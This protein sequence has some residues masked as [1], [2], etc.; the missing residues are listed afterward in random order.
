MREK[1][2]F[3][4]YLIWFSYLIL[5][6]VLLF[7]HGFLLSRKTLNDISQCVSIEN[8][9]EKLDSAA[10]YE[11]CQNEKL[12]NIVLSSGSAI[13]C[14]P[15]RNRVVFILVDALRYDFTEFNGN[16][17]NPLYYQNRLPI[18]HET[19]TKRPNKSRVFRFMADPPTTTLQRIKALVTG[20]LPT[21]VDA[22]SNFAAM[23][24]HEDNII[25]QIY[26]NNL[27]AVLLGDDTW[28]RLLPG[29]WL[30][31]HTM[32][33]FHTWDLDTVDT[34]IDSKI[35]DELAKDDWDLLIAHYL[36]VDHA[37]HRYGPNH[38]EMARKLDE[39]NER[40]KKIIEALPTDAILYVIGD[41]GMTETGDHGGETKAERT[42]A[43]FAYY[44]GE[45]GGAGDDILVGREIQQTD[46]APTI[47]S[48]LGTSPPA[49]SLGTVLIPILP[50]MDMQHTLLHLSNNL[51][52]ITQYLV[53]YGEESQQVSLDRLAE[54]INV[55]R[56]H[57]EK[58]ATVK[59]DEQLQKYISDVRSHT[60][61]IRTVFR[62]V[63]VEFDSLAMMRSLLLLLLAIFFNWIISEGI[64]LERIPFVFS[65][66]FV[67]TGLVSV[68]ICISVCYSAFYFALLDN[69]E[70]A[71]ILSTGLISGTL[72]CALVILHWD[73]IT[74]KWYE[75][76]THFYERFARTALFA[77]AAVLV[78]NS[79][80]IEEGTVLSYLSLS[81]LGLIAWNVGTVKALGLWASCGLAL[82][83]TR[84]YRGCREEQG[85]CWTSG[86][87]G[88]TGE[89]SRGALV[90]ALG[91]VAATVS[92]ARR[93]VNWRG[94]GVVLAG[95]FTCAHFAVGWGSLGSLNRSRLLA[96]V[97]WLFIVTSFGLLL[98]K[99]RSG[100]ITPLI[101][102]SLLFYLSNCLVL[103]VSFAPTAALALLSGFLSLNVVS[104]LK[105][106]ATSKLSCSARCS[107]GLACLWSLLASYHYY[108]SGHHPTLS[109]I[110]WAA[111]FHAGDP[112]YFTFGHIIS[113][114]LMALNLFGMPMMFGAS[115]PL[116]ALYGRNDSATLGPRM[117]MAAV[118]SV[119]LKFA[120]CYAIRVFACALSATI[121]CRHLMIW[122]VFTPKLI[123][124]AGSCVAALAGTLLGALITVW[125]LPKQTKSS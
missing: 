46:L 83:L 95:I 48:A 16:L 78:S 114:T 2:N 4:L 119:C 65:S 58:I 67:P 51:K 66:S 19:V 18:I 110:R 38:P 75:G 106:D 70:S 89:A 7:G 104:M 73:G 52:Q 44:G 62:E 91:S 28:E 64:P 26:R 42:A 22:S 69:L 107:S 35:Y 5:S 53:R 1:W 29:R 87:N 99:D 39:T 97:A 41:H 105:N 124:E 76:R 25:D 112:N 32:Y 111:V 10:K 121:H 92:I 86:Q 123:F 24:L 55:T 13:T 3:I 21:F 102:C 36:G 125:H 103:G 56:D 116:L 31:S 49:P 77:S 108:G 68:A 59:T 61:N 94:Y 117:Q 60:D 115:V 79:Y 12:N 20:S 37:G 81:V 6:A 8:A 23:E 43:I 74:Q 34:E 57:I 54:L 17:E 122:G 80:I 113:F 100:P 11:S 40:L 14:S 71:I 93:N 90:L 9:C 47:T 50:K 85:D 72:T 109:H 120:L 45:M 96:R 101:I 84:S 118:F 30:R 98:K 15:I 63:W 27:K 33:S 82:A 88:L